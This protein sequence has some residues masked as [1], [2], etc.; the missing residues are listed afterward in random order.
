MIY[1]K[2][3]LKNIIKIH[4]SI[5]LVFLSVILLIRSMGLLYLF[6]KNI[7][8]VDFVLIISYVI[9]PIIY[10]TLPISTFLSV[11][12]FFYEIKNNHELLILSNT[13][14]SNYE[15]AKPIISFSILITIF[16]FFLSFYLSPLSFEK[17]KNKTRFYRKEFINT[18]IKEKVFTPLDRN[19]TIYVNKILKTGELEGISVIENDEI[20]SQIITIA[21]KG[22]IYASKYDSIYIIIN[23]GVRQRLKNS[24]LETLKFEEIKVKL[25]KGANSSTKSE[26]KNIMEMSLLD[27]IS[28]DEIFGNKAIQEINRIKAEIH[29]RILWPLYNVATT[30]IFLPLFLR[31]KYSRRSLKKP[32]IFIVLA[33][34]SMFC[35]HFLSTSLA[36]VLPSAII[37]SYI[38]IIFAILLSFYL[39]RFS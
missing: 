19:T 27:I 4:L 37:L 5:T 13:G 8:I 28:N 9:P 24:K 1:K 10:T 20:N 38:Q 22:K 12:Y 15:I 21:K 16:S 35:I 2:Y 17:L 3:L 14:V 31:Q 32:L 18:S 33:I 26:K 36:S 34:I 7:S 29:S 23:D 30:M 6:S 25:N 11:M 39:F